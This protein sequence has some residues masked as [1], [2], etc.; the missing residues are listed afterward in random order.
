MCAI[1]W[2]ALSRGD[3]MT[4]PSRLFNPLHGQTFDSCLC[5]FDFCA[6]QRFAWNLRFAQLGKSCGVGCYSSIARRFPVDS[7]YID[8]RL[9][10][11][12]IAVGTQL[13][14]FCIGLSL[15]WDSRGYWHWSI[16]VT[17][18]TDLAPGTHRWLPPLGKQLVIRPSVSLLPPLLLPLHTY[19][20]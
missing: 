16:A 5:H 12:S 1:L 4:L 15:R 18:A 3:Q 8:P 10:F 11:P 9:I 7:V 14:H 6:G 20:L 17:P 13:F 2:A 19:G